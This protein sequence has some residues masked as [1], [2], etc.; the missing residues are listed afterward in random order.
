MTHWWHDVYSSSLACPRR[1]PLTSRDAISTYMFQFCHCFHWRPLKLPIVG[2]S[3]NSRSGRTQIV[4]ELGTAFYHFKQVWMEEAACHPGAVH[5]TLFHQIW[6]C[7][8]ASSLNAK[9][10][11]ALRCKMFWKNTRAMSSAF[12]WPSLAPRIL[13][14]WIGTHAR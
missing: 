4:G 8:R 11:T 14:N 2:P 10:R 1:G 3:T 13:Q 6:F 7:S 5:I 12:Y 9:G